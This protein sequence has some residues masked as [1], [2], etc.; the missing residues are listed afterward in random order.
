MR[1][2]LA[3]KP[4]API[5]IACDPAECHYLA[6]RY[7]MLCTVLLEAL[8]ECAVL[9]IASHMPI[10]TAIDGGRDGAAHLAS[11]PTKVATATTASTP[12]AA[13]AAAVA[14]AVPAGLGVTRIGRKS[15]C[16]ISLGRR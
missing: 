6:V 12:T 7:A 11:V 1:Q 13:I 8:H 15:S 10:A 9:H 3:M 2:R 4:E 5:A 16:R 14:A